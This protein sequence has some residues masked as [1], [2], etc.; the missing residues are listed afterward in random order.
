MPEIV[1]T[2]R[3]P[4]LAIAPVAPALGEV[5][6]NTTDNKLYWWNGTT[7]KDASGG[8]AVAAPEVF[9]GPE[10]PP[11]T[12]VLWIDTDEPS[13]PGPPLLVS[14]LPSSPTEGMEVYFQN[15][16][17]ATLG[18]EWHLRYRATSASS[19]KWEFVGGGPMLATGMGSLT[20]TTV[21]T[22]PLTG[23]PTFT[24][25]LAGEYEVTIMG[26]SQQNVAGLVGMLLALGVNGANSAPY[27]YLVGQTTYDCCDR[28]AI[29]KR[30]LAA[31]DVL[32]LRCQNEQAVS[33]SWQVGGLS[34]RPIRVG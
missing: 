27:S 1:G 28:T 4:R 2:L 29:G 13:W 31:G 10:A 9:I 16:A 8:G 18:V 12:Q 24:V 6:Y 21:T 5:Y 22:A 11:S 34:L 3:T 26:R 19:Y 32:T 20:Q 33:V 15:S 17:M 23:G 30:E 25:P 14:V 7:W